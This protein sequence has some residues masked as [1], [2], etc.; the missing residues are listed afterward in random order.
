MYEFLPSVLQICSWKYLMSAYALCHSVSSLSMQLPICAENLIVWSLH[1][2][3]RSTCDNHREHHRILET[4]HRKD[5]SL[6]VWDIVLEYDTVFFYVGPVR[7]YLINLWELY[8]DVWV[9]LTKFTLIL[10]FVHVLSHYDI[11]LTKSTD[12]VKHWTRFI[13]KWT[14]IAPV[15]TATTLRGFSHLGDLWTSL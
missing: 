1:I 12:H 11:K 7:I 3:S 5:L 4:R 10:L 13:M 14:T 6:T 8:L 2:K 15:A 9:T